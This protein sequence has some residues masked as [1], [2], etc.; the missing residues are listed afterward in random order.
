M[1]DYGA[2]PRG[3]DSAT[4]SSKLTFKI[5]AIVFAVT[6]AA[7]VA[8]TYKGSSDQISLF[9]NPNDSG[10]DAT[11]WTLRG[12]IDDGIDGD[13]SKNP[14]QLKAEDTFEKNGPFLRDSPNQS[15]DDGRNTRDIFTAKKAQMLL[16]IDNPTTSLLGGDDWL[17]APFAV[18]E[19]VRENGEQEVGEEVNYW[20]THSGDIGTGSKGYPY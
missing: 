8:V 18:P 4:S 16:Q 3:M 19:D 20:N 11:S 15:G 12:L 9:Q 5:S 10:L 2:I 13:D 7:A 17:G 1:R 14:F 6:L